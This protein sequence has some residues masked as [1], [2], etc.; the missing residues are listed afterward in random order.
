MKNNRFKEL[1]NTRDS[2]LKEQELL[3]QLIENVEEDIA[4]QCY[5]CS[6][7]L[8]VDY[9]EGDYYNKAYTTYS[10][11]CKTCGTTLYEYTKIHD[12]YG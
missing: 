12:Y 1:L 5:H 8:I 3:D 7:E 10:T 9:Y 2:Y 4:N 11:V 6:T